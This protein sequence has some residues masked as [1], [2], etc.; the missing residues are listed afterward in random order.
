[1]LWLDSARAVITKSFS[2]FCII[3]VLPKLLAI[4]TKVN[5]SQRRRGLLSFGFHRR[6]WHQSASA[7]CPAPT[8]AVSAVPRKISI[9][10]AFFG[11]FVTYNASPVSKAP[12]TKLPNVT[13][14]WFHTHHCPNETGAPNNLPVGIKNM[15]TIECSY[16]C[17]KH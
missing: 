1:M 6:P 15:F 16:P 9:V 14:I 17:A 7:T 12:E 11:M 10:A 4:A 8:R 2:E 5:S 3:A 13:G